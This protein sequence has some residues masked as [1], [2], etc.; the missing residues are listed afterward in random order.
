MENRPSLK[1]C[2][3]CG[4]KISEEAPAGLCPLCLLSEVSIPTE[5]AASEG[6]PQPP[7]M[8][9]LAAA[10]PQ[11]E[12]VGIIG[13]GGM[14]YVF[15]ARQPKLDR[16]VALKILPERLAADPAFAERFS[17]EGRVLARLN[18]PNI[19]TIHD[20]GQAD[21]FFYLI[22]EYVDGVNLRQAM[23]VGRFTPEQALAVVPKICDALEFAH[24]EGILHRDIKPEN[25]LLD[26]KGRVKISDFGISRIIGKTNAA[27]GLTKSTTEPNV[28]GIIGTPQYM[29]PEQ[30][31]N[32]RK[33]DQRADVYAL[34]V[35]FYEMLTGELPLGRFAP[36]SEKSMVDPRLDEVVLRALEKEPARRTPSA[37]EVKTQV[38]TILGAPPPVPRTPSAAIAKE[39]ELI[40]FARY[41]RTAVWAGL[42]TFVLC[43]L[44]A[45]FVSFILPDTYLATARVESPINA[46][47]PYKLQTEVER[48]RSQNI[49][50]SVAD[51]LGLAE[52][53]QKRYGTPAP[54]DGAAVIDL[55]RKMTE[56]KTGRG[57]ALLE[58]RC[59]SDS[60]AE[61]AEIANKI[62][63]IYCAGNRARLIDPAVAPQSP[64]R[65]NRPL[66]IGIGAL[67]GAAAASLI[68][69][70]AG[71][72]SVYRATV[73]QDLR[74]K[75]Q[76][77]K[78]RGMRRVA[79]STEA[80]ALIIIISGIGFA[81]LRARA[82]RQEAEARREAE[83][84]AAAH[85]SRSMETIP[86]NPVEAPPSDEPADTP[87]ASRLN[88]Q[89]PNARGEIAKTIELTKTTRGIGNRISVWTESPLVPGESITAAVPN[90]D[91]S[92][93]DSITQT[94]TI[95]GRAGVRT[96]TVF[97]WLIPAS[98]EPGGLSNAE[99]MLQTDL[100]KPLTLKSGS[101][102]PL[103]I[104]TNRAGGTM[105]GRLAFRPTNPNS[106][107]PGSQATV[108]ITMLT[109]VSPMVLGYFTSTVPAGCILQ[110]GANI[111]PGGEADVH[112]A[113]SR[114]PGFDNE[115]CRWDFP[116]EFSVEQM[117]AAVAQVAVGLFLTSPVGG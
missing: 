43:L 56:V 48:I 53:W 109:N 34:G 89:T 110:A 49:L 93:E 31:E 22:M 72:I 107:P 25:I 69:P 35:V 54:L 60:S 102:F 66:I 52:R 117:R 4:A 5:G 20:F 28:T 83:R 7:A 61:A 105:T 59:F 73:A 116:P 91:G 96:S 64:A 8:E 76:A 24:H 94:I 45:G 75:P 15:K 41:L 47:D 85:A 84:A 97:T 114:G 92:S 12:I 112:T 51:S 87:S 63:D 9:E 36:P 99:Q 70:V 103:F 2:P 115:N 27:E 79:L 26:S 44:A 86:A 42:V 108:H 80:I 81:L 95:R 6:N 68:G 78:G 19:V 29:A 67:L 46:G 10:F 3:K 30:I 74:R 101:P 55:L 77:A 104:L 32:P 18:H 50:L 33:V 37:H 111:E 62:A 90:P 11:L 58:I 17:Q 82:S 40:G 21:G 65:P 38:E 113:I 98:F 57:T 71:F 16:F 39:M 1:Q 100:L 13:R 106:V 23:K 14:G 88:S